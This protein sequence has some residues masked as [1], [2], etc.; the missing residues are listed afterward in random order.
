MFIAKRFNDN[1]DNRNKYFTYSKNQN[2]CSFLIKRFNAKS[3]RQPILFSESTIIELLDR[4]S[5]T[6][7]CY[8]VE[9]F[10]PGEITE[11]GEEDEIVAAFFHY[12]YIVSEGEFC[13]LIKRGIANMICK[14]I[15]YKK[16]DQQDQIQ[17]IMSHHKCN[18]IC[19]VFTLNDKNK[20]K[21]KHGLFPLFTYLF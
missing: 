10:I 16:S 20:W 19:H 6:N 15:F 14:S 5:W 1:A 21:D 8:I 18:E 3:G 17:E 7:A 11:Y 12:C 13:C 9:P 2:Y 4:P